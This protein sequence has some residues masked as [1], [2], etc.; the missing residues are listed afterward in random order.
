MVTA[1]AVLFVPLGRLRFGG[2]L[3][4]LLERVS[5]GWV[6]LSKNPWLLVLLVSMQVGGIVIIAVRLQLL[7]QAMSQDV[8]LLHCLVMAS[9]SIMTRLMNISPGGLGVREGIVAGLSTIIGADFGVAVL[10]VGVDRLILVLF[11][12]LTVW[13]VRY[14]VTSDRNLRSDA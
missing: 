14:D 9:A 10:A 7:F 12:G 13:L 11:S 8:N 3:R 2:R 4:I 1:I 5:D 6:A